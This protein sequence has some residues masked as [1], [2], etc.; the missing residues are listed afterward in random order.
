MCIK[1]YVYSCPER[2]L[3]LILV[4]RVVKKFVKMASNIEKR[5]QKIEAMYVAL[6]RSSKKRGKIIEEIADHYCIDKATVYRN[7]NI[8]R[9]K[10]KYNLSK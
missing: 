1:S 9:V 6:W 3:F 5:K 2:N 10:V 4:F 8:K 7:I